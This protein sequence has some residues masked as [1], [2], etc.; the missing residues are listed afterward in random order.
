METILTENLTKALEYE[1]LLMGSILEMGREKTDHLIHHRTVELSALTVREQAVAEQLTQ[2]EK[3]RMQLSEKV[4]S[5]L[6]ITEASPT[7]SDLC[8][9]MEAS[10]REPLEK[11]LNKLR[12]TMT[13]LR[14]QNILNTQLIGQAMEFVNFNIQLLA[15]PSA[16]VPQYGRG[17]R[18]TSDKAP[19]RSIMDLRS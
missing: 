10:Q 4:A 11:M 6:G 15:K 16:A 3:V 9:K 7:L 8:E 14:E 1:V 12:N 17:G 5:S 13:A 19:A 2:L 18:D